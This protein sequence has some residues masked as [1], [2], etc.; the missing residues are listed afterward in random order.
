MDRL[1]LSTYSTNSMQIRMDGTLA[2]NIHLSYAQGWRHAS[3]KPERKRRAID[4]T[5]LLGKQRVRNS[6]DWVNSK[7]K[8]R[9]R[10]GSHRMHNTKQKSKGTACH[11]KWS[12]QNP[13]F[14]FLH[15]LSLKGHLLTGLTLIVMPKRPKTTAVDSHFQS[16]VMKGWSK[17]LNR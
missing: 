10:N 13:C 16:A 7:D 14:W 12:Y 8:V 6:S 17:V 4:S 11:P 3:E 9:P 15:S 5:R 2:I 1:R